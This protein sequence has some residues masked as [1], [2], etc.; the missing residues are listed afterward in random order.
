MRQ[1]N[2]DLPFRPSAM[3]AFLFRLLGVIGLGLAIDI[4]TSPEA[5]ALTA[6][7]TTL[8]FQ[9][10]QGATKPPSQTVSISRSG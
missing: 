8:T 2:Q 3:Y 9:A 1:P 7:P 5:L 10:V 6:N 4:W